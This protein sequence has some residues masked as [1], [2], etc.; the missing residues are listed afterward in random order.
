MTE[1]DFRQEFIS[2]LK[3]WK[4]ARKI[5]FLAFYRDFIISFFWFFV[6]RCVFRNAQNMA[7]SDFWENFFPGWKCRKYAE[8]DVFAD[9]YWTFSLY[10][11]VFFTKN[12]VDSNSQY[13]LKLK[14]AGQIVVPEKWIFFNFS[15]LTQYFIHEFS[16]F[17][18]AGSFIR[19]LVCSFV[20]FSGSFYY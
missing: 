10:F 12:I 15:S 16:L 2:S 3:C 6:Q 19:L 13:F 4:Y 1:P 17:S 11:V 9:F 20:R 7:E 8:N 5:G 18:F 14:I